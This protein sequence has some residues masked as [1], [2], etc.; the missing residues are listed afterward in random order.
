VISGGRPA[1]HKIQGIGAGFIPTN[2]DKDLLNDVVTVSNEEA[3]AWAQRLSREEG[4]CC[5]I[6]SGANACAAARIAAKP[7]NKGKMIVTIGCSAGERY[8]STPLY[9]GRAGVILIH[10]AQVAGGAPSATVR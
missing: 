3:F 2:L 1:P 5:G 6:S 10:H 8:L 9:E 4:I 7:E